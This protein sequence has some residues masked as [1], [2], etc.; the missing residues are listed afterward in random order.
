[1]PARRRTALP[2]VLLA[3]LFGLAALGGWLSLSLPGTA[4]RAAIVER[5]TGETPR[6]RID[7]YVQ[8][9]LRGDTPAALAAWELPD[10]ELPAG[11]SALLAARRDQVTAD[12]LLKATLFDGNP[13]S[14]GQIG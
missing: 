13:P 10:W 8:A 9:V 5:C 11:R 3:V 12:L 4:L 2:L 6:A 1:M 7:A 14:S